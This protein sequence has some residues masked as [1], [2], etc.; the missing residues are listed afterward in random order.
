MS[1]TKITIYISLPKCEQTKPLPYR[2]YI[3]TQRNDSGVWL[4]KRSASTSV[5]NTGE[6]VGLPPKVKKFESLHKIGISCSSKLN[7]IA[8]AIQQFQTST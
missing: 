6:K 8:V 1:S 7:N 5:Y 2:F 3:K 4:N